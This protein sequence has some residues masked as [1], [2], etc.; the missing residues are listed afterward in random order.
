[1]KVVTR[2]LVDR[3]RGNYEKKQVEY[4]PEEM[5][6]MAEES[7]RYSTNPEHYQDQSYNW[8]R[9]KGRGR[10]LVLGPYQRPV[11]GPSKEKP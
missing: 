3:G 11:T 4:T 2:I 5:Q 7:L 8:R 10:G 6:D 9:R 1:M